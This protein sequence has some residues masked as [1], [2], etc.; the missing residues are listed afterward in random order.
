M[1]NLFAPEIT[2]EAIRVLKRDTLA[3]QDFSLD[4]VEKAVKAAFEE[5]G[6]PVDAHRLE[7]L[8]LL[9]KTKALMAGGEEVSVETIQDLVETTLM[10]IGAGDVAK[11]YI[12]YRSRQEEIRSNR[13][14]PDQSA[15]ADYIHPGKYS[16]HLADE[17][18]R[19]LYH[20]TVSRV[21]DM[22]VRRWP[23]LKEEINEIFKSVQAKK[24]L[25]SMRSMQFAGKAI[26]E[27]NA[28]QF[29]CSYLLIDKVSAF[30]DTLYL[31][32]CGCGVG[33]SVQHDHVEQLPKLSY[34]DSEV[35]RH[36][37]I[38]DTIEG[39]ANALHALVTSYV[40]GYHVEFN[41]SKIRS[42]GELLKTSGG[43]A[44]GHMKLKWALEKVRGVLDKAQ[45]RQLRPVEC[46]DL[47]CFSADAV[48]S[49][50][51]R[52][53]ATIALF[54]IEDGE[55]MTA[56][57]G[58]W[59]DTHPWRSNSNNSVVLKRGDVN[60]RAF[61]RV[62]KHIKEFGEPG[63]VFVNDYDHGFNPCVEIN[64]NPVLTIDDQA[65]SIIDRKRE[66]GMFIPKV[67]LGERHT[68]VA[69]CN[70]TEMNAA[71]F[72]SLE[73]MLYA[74]RM[75]SKLGTLQ[76][77]YT[78]FPFLGW[79]TEVIAEKEALLGVS[80]TGMMDSPEIALDP[81]NQKA[82]ALAVVESN[83]VWAEKLGISQAARTTC[84]KPAG[85]TSLELGCVGSGIHAHHARRYIRRVRANKDQP[86]FKYFKSKNP[87]M[88]VYTGKEDVWVIEFP[89]K[90]P[91]GAA[92]KE[93]TTAV[94]FL[95]LVE[96]KH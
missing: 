10:E 13:L 94:E 74:A 90:A 82:A 41:Y 66:E 93:D 73:D 15:I 52:R 72:E 78:S 40:K 43:R 38:A 44:P 69:F 86:V 85:S 12:L 87:H 80:M 96:Q 64:L 77:A 63:F 75:A 3:T 71:A 23:H 21:E 95:E 34:I 2:K 16:R 7:Q 46:Y 65:M 47:V 36:Y 42:K 48:L 61:K 27:I 31:L 4:K 79:V 45:G 89:V 9:V 17:S 11:A 32:L 18:R 70:L 81:E 67:K 39:W 76:A 20:E 26:E 83:K 5:V 30:R 8:A 84:V 53:S 60:K 54:S 35:V 92:L 19:E 29:N 6:R 37:T 56:K 25:P 58:G 55:M 28:R 14:E 1:T 33:Y 91:A 57:T 51:I 59:F 22:H 62:F 24:I 88:C 49:G 68:G 50:G